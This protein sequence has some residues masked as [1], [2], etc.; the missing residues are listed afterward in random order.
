MKATRGKRSLHVPVLL[1]AMAGL[2]LSASGCI[3]DASSNPSC[4]PTPSGCYPDLTINWEVRSQPTVGNPLIT[5]DAAGGAN[6]VV[7]LIDGGCLGSALVE[8][9]GLCPAGT[10]SGSFVA[11]LPNA[12]TY[13]VSVE[14]HS[15]GPNGPKLS[16]T[17][18][19]V[20]PVDCGGQ[21]ATP[22]ASM[23]VDF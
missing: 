4:G 5:C 7:A 18:I 16:E 13:N 8:F 9:D 22:T 14:L 19:L 1:A 15:G 12:G 11:P 2:A 10:A 20:Q 6:A 23:F 3:I 17:P 21:T